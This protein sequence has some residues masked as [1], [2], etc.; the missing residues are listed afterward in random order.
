MEIFL[1]EL[2]L[3]DKKQPKHLKFLTEIPKSLTGTHYGKNE[4]GQIGFNSMLYDRME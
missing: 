4:N 1:D 3:A 2:A